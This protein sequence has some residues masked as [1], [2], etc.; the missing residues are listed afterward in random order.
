MIE[1]LKKLT[2]DAY[3]TKKTRQTIFKEIKSLTVKI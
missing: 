3:H 1:L 2:L